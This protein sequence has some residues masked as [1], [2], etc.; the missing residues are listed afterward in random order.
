MT[1]TTR[2]QYLLPTVLPH[3]I[4]FDMVSVWIS[5]R[6]G[7]LGIINKQASQDLGSQNVK[8][9]IIGQNHDPWREIN[10]MEGDIVQLIS[11]RVTL[12]LP[13]RF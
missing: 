7:R 2:D 11:G 1:L 12:R 3:G 6:L 9:S 10:F 5:P 8:A 4:S 13:P